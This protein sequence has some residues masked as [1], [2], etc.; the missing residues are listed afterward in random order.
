MVKNTLLAVILVIAV[1]LTIS[2]CIGEG[3]VYCEDENVDAVYECGDGSTKVVSTLLG[4]GYTVYKP[5][6]T[7]FSCPVVA[8]EHMSDECTSFQENVQ[9]SPVN[10]CIP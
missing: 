2:G 7:S 6:G 10:I 8:P 9:C 3:P 5:D 1:A 4:A